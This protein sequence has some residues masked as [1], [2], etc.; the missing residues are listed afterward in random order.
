MSGEFRWRSLRAASTLS[1]PLAR[2]HERLKKDPRFLPLFEAA[3]WGGDN[4]ARL[5]MADLAE[6]LGLLA[7]ARWIREDTYC[8]A[9][10]TPS[11]PPSAPAPD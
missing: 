3:M 11:D 7:A 2:E 5:A 9:P 1:E 8:G 10:F 6:E 4:T